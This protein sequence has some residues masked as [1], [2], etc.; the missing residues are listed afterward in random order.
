MTTGRGAF[1]RALPL[2][3]GLDRDF[4]EVPDP[5]KSYDRI[6]YT[7][8]PRFNYHPSIAQDLVA[9]GVDVAPPRHRST[10]LSTAHDPLPSRRNPSPN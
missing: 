9:A 10:Q 8:Y 2:A 4:L 7:A 3:P 1:E 6:V 5:G